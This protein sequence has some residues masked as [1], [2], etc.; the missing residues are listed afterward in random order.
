MTQS[1][2]SK[3]SHGRPDGQSTQGRA[4]CPF[5]ISHPHPEAALRIVLGCGGRTL[6]TEAKVHVPLWVGRELTGSYRGEFGQ[7]GKVLAKLTH[8]VG[9]GTAEKGT[10]TY[11][12]I[13]LGFPVRTSRNSSKPVFKTQ[14]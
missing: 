3:T 2:R 8:D 9:A 5:Q 1:L 7:A 11:G 10:S 4:E 13:I 6:G 12:G 14:I